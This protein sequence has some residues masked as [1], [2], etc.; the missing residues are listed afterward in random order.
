M[1]NV[2]TIARREYSQYFNTP[3]SYAVACAILL[4]VGL[5]FALQVF[6]A[7]QSALQGGQFGAGPAPDA[8]NITGVFA[9]MLVLSAPALTMRLIS[10]E[11]RMGTLELL[12]TAPVQDWE[13]V[14]GKWLSSLLFLLTVLAVTLIFPLMLNFFL[15]S[16]GIDQGL[17]MSAYLGVILVSAAFLGVGVGISSLFSNQIA[18]F[19]VTLMLFVVFWWLFGFLAQSLQGPASA[20]FSYLDMGGH[21]NNALNRGVVNPADVIYFLSVTVFG[22]FIGTASVEA[23]R[24]S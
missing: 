6:A 7:Y 24:W 4:V 22:L 3:V 8:S 16:P 2:W 18:S 11:N 20:L 13:L 21:F 1:R 10:D 17:M 9:F 5:I 12:L 19:F 23:R 15:V 14:V